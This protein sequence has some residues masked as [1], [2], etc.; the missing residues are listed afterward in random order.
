MSA[1]LDSISQRRNNLLITTVDFFL[2]QSPNPCLSSLHFSPSLTNHSHQ[3]LTGLQRKHSHYLLVLAAPQS[4][5]RS[6]DIN[7]F[8]HIYQ[9]QFMSISSMLL[10]LIGCLCLVPILPHQN[11]RHVL[12]NAPTRALLIIICR[13]THF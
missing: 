2:S 8:V 3:K 6:E 5:L 9:K 11:H 7:L 10:Y 12:T 13:K 4:L 1:S